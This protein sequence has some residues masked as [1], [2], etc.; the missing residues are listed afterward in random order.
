VIDDGQACGTTGFTSGISGTV[1]CAAGQVCRRR[2]CYYSVD[3][4][5]N[6][7]AT[8]TSNIFYID[9]QSPSVSVTGAPSAWQN[10]D[11]TA[12]VSC[13]DGSGSGCNAGTHRLRVYN[14]PAPPSCSTDYASYAVVPPGTISSHSWACGAARDNIGNTGFSIPV[15]KPYGFSPAASCLDQPELC[16]NQLERLGHRRLRHK[17]F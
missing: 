6:Q 10:T 17:S 9:R 15:D 14:P 8:V 11:A 3:N 4:V 16:H 12:G 5:G 2:V 7:E 1:T 13:S